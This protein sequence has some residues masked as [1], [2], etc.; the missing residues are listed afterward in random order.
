MGLLKVGAM[1]GKRPRDSARRVGRGIL[2]RQ[3][4][5]SRLAVAVGPGCV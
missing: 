4:E 2:V 3:H 1:S 5:T